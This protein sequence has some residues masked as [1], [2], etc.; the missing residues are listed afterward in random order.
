MI[1]FKSGPLELK[2]LL[3]IFLLPR[4]EATL[5]GQSFRCIDFEGSPFHEFFY[6]ILPR[7]FAFLAVGVGPCT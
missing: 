6:L 4:F 2:F 5:W 1:P 3:N 7:S